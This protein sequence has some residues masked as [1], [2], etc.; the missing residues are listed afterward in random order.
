MTKLTNHKIE[1]HVKPMGTKHFCYL[2][3]TLIGSFNTW[4]GANNYL[5]IK[6][7]EFIQNK[8][9]EIEDNIK[10]NRLK[11]NEPY[12]P[13]NQDDEATKEILAYHK[14]LKE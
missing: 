7:N 11:Q 9:K 10:R 4:H 6:V 3:G 1:T 5:V 2:N 12:Y 8:N 13:R 14:E